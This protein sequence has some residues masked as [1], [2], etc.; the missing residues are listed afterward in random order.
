MTSDDKRASNLKSNSMN[1][2]SK[3]FILV[4]TLKEKVGVVHLSIFWFHFHLINFGKLHETMQYAA[5]ESPG[6]TSSFLPEI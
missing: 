5:M 4:Y 6:S 1:G 2:I 3:A